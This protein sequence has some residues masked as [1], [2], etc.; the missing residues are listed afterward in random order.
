[1]G[2][3]S[4]PYIK[5]FVGNKQFRRDPLMNRGYFS[6]VAGLQHLLKGF[7][8]AGARLE[9]ARSPHTFPAPE[10]RKQ[11]V[12]L[13]AGFDTTY[14]RLAVRNAAALC[15]PTLTSTH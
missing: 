10:Q 2:Y 5:F 3:Y 7:L 9:C 13:G 11:I 1:M 4:D 12:S 6:R 14:W 15:L 8:A